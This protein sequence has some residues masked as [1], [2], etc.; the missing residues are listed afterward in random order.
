MRFQGSYES[1]VARE[2][3]IHYA[4]PFSTQVETGNVDILRG[5]W[6]DTF[7]DELKAFP[8][9]K[10]KDCVDAASRAFMGI[11][12]KGAMAYIN[13]LKAVSL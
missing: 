2:D 1:E 5:A 12:R 13:A 6:N 10:H 8:D 3:K 11:D 9:G 7:L 4:S